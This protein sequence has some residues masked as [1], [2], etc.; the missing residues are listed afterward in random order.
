MVA[1]LWSTS[2]SVRSL[3]LDD[4]WLATATADG[5]VALLHTE[6]VARQGR[7][8]QSG[9]GPAASR[10]LFQVPQGAACCVDLLDQ[11][12][13]AGSGSAFRRL[14]QVA[15]GAA[16]CVHLFDGILKTS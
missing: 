5:T 2:S 7:A 4:P 16:R 8:G 6:A 1:T 13:V 9:A 11:L 15:L 12:L 14:L 10:R 3:K